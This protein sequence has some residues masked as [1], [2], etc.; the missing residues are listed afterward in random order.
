[1]LTRAAKRAQQP[2][3]SPAQRQLQQSC[4]CSF[5]AYG[6]TFVEQRFY[7]CMTCDMT[8]EKGVGF[9]RGCK[10]NCHAGHDVGFVGRIKA[11]CDCGKCG[12]AL[13]QQ[14]GLVPLD[15]SGRAWVDDGDES[16]ADGELDQ[17]LSRSYGDKRYWDDRYRANPAGDGDEW[18][19]GFEELAPVVLPQLERARAA[20][21]SS[22]GGGGRGLRILMLGCGDSKFSADLYD[23][24][25]EDIVNVDISEVVIDK[26]AKQQATARPKMR[27]L[28]A[29]ATDRGLFETG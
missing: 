23:A 26:M 11:Y 24:G 3:E 10:R 13:S 5:A 17:R 19:V 1:M 9:C 16:E 28:A 7:E 20:V 27:W 22:G 6:E 21:A 4:G 15:S 2:D 14:Q 25:F 18:L 29:D 12:C 8:L